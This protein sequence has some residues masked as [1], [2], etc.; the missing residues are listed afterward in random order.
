MMRPWQFLAILSG[1]IIAVV[2]AFASIS[3]NAT[4]GTDEPA[5][6]GVS[7]V[8]N[9]TMFSVLA[10]AFDLGMVASVFGFFHWRQSNRT[11]AALCVALFLIASLFSIHSVRGYIALN[12]TKSLAPA[13]RA[14]DVYQSMKRELDS[15]QGHLVRM[16]EKKL[17]AT[18]RE[19]AHLDRDIAR[20][21]ER[22]AGTR[23]GLASTDSGRHVS[24]LAGLEWFLAITLWFF[25]ATCWTA[26]FGI[27]GKHDARSRSTSATTN[28]CTNASSSP[29]TKSSSISSTSSSGHAVLAADATERAPGDSVSRFVATFPI[30]QPE[31]CASIYARYR[32]WARAEG[33]D[34]LPERKFYA[35]LVALGA[36]RFRDGRNGPMKYVI[37]APAML[38]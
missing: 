5:F 8:T 9:A 36:R 27:D 38:N 11:G 37:D 22:I 13:E 33:I 24:P 34:A 30:G 17:A 31:H 2:I 6:A 7:I 29:S 15:D 14:A 23:R 3:Y 16:R 25:N 26:W 1:A 4:L 32:Q 12:I 10:L 19:R 20:L 21:E 18:T 28:P 35:R